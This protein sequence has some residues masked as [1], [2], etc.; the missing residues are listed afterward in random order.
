VTFL[1]GAAPPII[2]AAIA[3]RLSLGRPRCLAKQKDRGWLLRR[4]AFS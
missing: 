4:A 2:N 3:C 1:A